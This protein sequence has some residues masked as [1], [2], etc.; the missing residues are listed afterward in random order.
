MDHK[1]QELTEELHTEVIAFL[2]DIKNEFRG[3]PV[4][5]H[6][7]NKAKELLKKYNRCKDNQ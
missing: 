3:N 7:V 6:R 2:N 5:I 1:T 4:G